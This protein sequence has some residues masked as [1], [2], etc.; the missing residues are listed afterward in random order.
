MPQ[1][2][3]FGLVRLAQAV[4]EFGCLRRIR[5]HKEAPRICQGGGGLVE[6]PE[7]RDDGPGM[8]RETIERVFEPYYTTK[9]GGTGLGLSIT[10]GI[11]SEHGGNIE[12]TSHPGQGCQ[13]L[14]TL[15]LHQPAAIV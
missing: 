15:P 12:I 2:R 3:D 1:D 13:V 4:H 7:I 8:D 14:I 6:P 9:P 5:D 11:I 10:R